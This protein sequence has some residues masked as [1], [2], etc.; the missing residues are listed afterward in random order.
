MG[1][2]WNEMLG[3]SFIKLEN[4]KPKELVLSEWQ[5]Q[6]KFV[7]ET[8]KKPRP[9]IMFKVLEEDGKKLEGDDIKEYT[10]TAIRALSKLKPIIEEAEAKGES[11]IKVNI[12]RVGEGR[13]TEYSIKKIE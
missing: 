12:V 9:G 3:G 13:K 4:G 10:V 6:T 7:D 1:I 8:T 5:V 11:S 2:D